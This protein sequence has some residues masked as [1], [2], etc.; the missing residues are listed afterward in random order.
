[1][2]N[3]APP[4]EGTES[5]RSE[6]DDELDD[7]IAGLGDGDGLVAGDGL[8]AVST[9]KVYSPE[10]GCPSLPTTRHRTVNVPVASDSRSA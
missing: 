6:G 10:I 7:V 8:G 2:G 4:P 1:M 9:V 3:A 5:G